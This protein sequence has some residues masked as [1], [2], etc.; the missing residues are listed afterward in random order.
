MQFFKAG[1]L[2]RW[3]KKIMYL[4]TYIALQIFFKK[5]F[6]PVTL[7][8]WLLSFSPLLLLNS[9]LL[10]WQALAIKSWKWHLALSTWRNAMRS[11]CV[12][13]FSLF[14]QDLQNLSFFRANKKEI[15]VLYIYSIQEATLPLL[16]LNEHNR[17]AKCYTC[18]CSVGG[19]G[20]VLLAWLK[21][22]SDQWMT[23]YMVD[24]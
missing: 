1:S 18:I 5:H 12:H 4:P 21:C 15:T 20:R 24:L 2:E 22:Y 14:F 19:Y 7:I 8:T 16:A 11:A 10:L 17:H 13:S 3:L 23:N 6:S 9:L